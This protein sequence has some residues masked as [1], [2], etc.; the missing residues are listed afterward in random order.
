MIELLREQYRINNI[1]GRIN[2]QIG[3]QLRPGRLGCGQSKTWMWPGCDQTCMW[4][5][6]CFCPPYT[7]FNQVT[8][9]LVPI[10]VPVKIGKEKSAVPTYPNNFIES[11]YICVHRQLHL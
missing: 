4:P 8:G 3:Q 9:T 1:A 5:V 6:N 7:H 10:D 2:I 11:S